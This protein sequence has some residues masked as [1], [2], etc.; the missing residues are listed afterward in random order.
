MDFFLKLG[1]ILKSPEEAVKG[2]GAGASGEEAELLFREEF[3]V[4]ESIHHPAVDD[5]GQKLEVN[6]QER[7][8]PGV[9]DEHLSLLRDGEN[10]AF[11]E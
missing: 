8:G 6:F 4:E 2:S 5:A 1:R 7:D 11:I 9:L 3:R 10:E